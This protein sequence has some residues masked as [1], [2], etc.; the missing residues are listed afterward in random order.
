M[1][2][3]TVENELRMRRVLMARKLK[4]CTIFQ[5][6][7]YIFDTETYIELIDWQNV[8]ITPPLLLLA[9][10]DEEIKR[11]MT[12][13]TFPKIIRKMTCVPC[14]IQPVERMI[15]FVTDASRKDCSHKNRKDFVRETAKLK[16][17]AKI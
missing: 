15:N 13:G 9:L 7:T 4:K 10:T 16:N 3:L 8:K 2:K 6:T 11:A 5:L 17:D 14:H 12:E 1:A